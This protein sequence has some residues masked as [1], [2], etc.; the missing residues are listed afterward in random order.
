MDKIICERLYELVITL[1]LNSMDF[2]LFIGISTVYIVSCRVHCPSIIILLIHFAFCACILFVFLT[3]FAVK[4]VLRIFSF[5]FSLVSANWRT[6][7][8]TMSLPC[9][10][11]L[12]Y[13][14]FIHKNVKFT[15][16]VNRVSRVCRTI[17]KLFVGFFVCERFKFVE[18]PTSN[19]QTVLS[20]LAWLHFIKSY[21]YFP[22]VG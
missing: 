3:L 2:L 11:Y 12:W 13:T 14:P 9:N 19:L 20:S 22:I 6:I 18:P 5:K 15:A 1:W 4:L 21:T 17:L 10:I 8:T 16:C 7:L